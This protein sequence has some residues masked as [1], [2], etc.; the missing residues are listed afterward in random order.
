MGTQP[1]PTHAWSAVC[2]AA[3]LARGQTLALH[4]HGQ[5]LALFHTHDGELF[6]LADHDPHEPA[7]RGRRALSAGRLTSRR[8]LPVVLARSGRHFDLA[9]GTCVDGGTAVAAFPVR[10]TDGAVEVAVPAV[11]AA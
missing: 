2:T 8:D 6:A 11:P 1:A 3:D 9:R 4:V 7:E 10:V 5:A